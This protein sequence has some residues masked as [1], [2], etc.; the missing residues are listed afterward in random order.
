MECS[1]KIQKTFPFI[2]TS[3][4]FTFCKTWKMCCCGKDPTNT[5]L[6][7]KLLYE[8]LPRIREL[9]QELQQKNKKLE[10]IATREEI[11]ILFCLIYFIENLYSLIVGEETDIKYKDISFY[12]C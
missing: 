8:N 4:E 7:E 2:K 9:R 6:L 5:I 3:F 10:Q 12:V 11:D 1:Q